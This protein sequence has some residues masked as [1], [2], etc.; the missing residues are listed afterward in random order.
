MDWASRRATVSARPPASIGAN[1]G[2]ARTLGTAR[3]VTAGRF[4]WLGRQALAAGRP[5][6][7]SGAGHEPVTAPNRSCLTY[8]TT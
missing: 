6:A 5:A 2:R 1:S 7:V 4:S 3:G 8:L